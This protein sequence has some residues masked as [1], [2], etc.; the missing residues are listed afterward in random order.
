MIVGGSTTTLVG[1]SDSTRGATGRMGA[2]DATATAR[3]D[4]AARPHELDSRRNDLGA[5]GVRPADSRVS[6]RDGPPTVAVG[7]IDLR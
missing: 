4:G 1:P 6:C 7:L 5:T 2:H 3:C